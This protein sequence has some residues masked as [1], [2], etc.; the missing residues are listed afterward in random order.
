ME[1]LK[2]L[3]NEM[4]K[5]VKNGKSMNL[6]VRKYSHSEMVER[7]VIDSEKSLD[8]DILAPSS[9]VGPVCVN[10]D[11]CVQRTFG[12]CNRCCCLE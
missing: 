10:E 5:V 3:I 11:A 4:K 9:V 1:D 6:I 2:D 12:K 7:C 8:I